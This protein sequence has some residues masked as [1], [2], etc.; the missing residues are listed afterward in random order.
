MGIDYKGSQG[1]TER[2]VALWE[3]EEDKKI[4]KYKNISAWFVLYFIV[5]FIHLSMTKVKVKFTL[6]QQAMKA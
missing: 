4:K 6:E 5:L 1:Q 3:E 2:A